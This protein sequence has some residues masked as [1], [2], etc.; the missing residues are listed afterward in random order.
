MRPYLLALLI[1]FTT[2]SCHRESSMTTGWDYNDP[3]NGGFQKVPFVEQETGPGLVLIEGGTFELYLEQDSIISDKKMEVVVP[4]YYLDEKEVSNYAYLEY[5]YWTKRTFSIDFPMVYTNALP[6]TLV[7]E[8]EMGRANNFVDN[9][10]RHPA[11]NNYPVVGVSWMQANNYCDWRTDRVNEFILI[12]EGILTYNP[13][14]INED[15]F[16]TEAYYAGQYESCVVT[17]LPDLD[18]MRAGGMGRKDLGERIVRME[19]GILLPHY[20]LP[21][22]AEWEYAASGGTTIDKKMK[23]KVDASLLHLGQFIN[24]SYYDDETFNTLMVSPVDAYLPNDLG[25]YNLSGNVSE[26]VSDTY[27]ERIDTSLNMHSPFVGPKTQ[28]PKESVHYKYAEKLSLVAYDIEQFEYFMDE[29]KEGYIP[30]NSKDSFAIVVFSRLDEYIDL[31]KQSEA[32]GNYMDA[33]EIMMIISHDLFDEM[34]YWHYNESPFGHEHEPPLLIDIK[35]YLAKSI[36]D[37]PG[38]IQF[39]GVSPYDRI[40][41][42]NNDSKDYPVYDSIIAQNDQRVYKGANW[43][44]TEKWV[45]PSFRRHLS[46]FDGSAVVGFRCAMDR[47][48]S[49]V[50]LGKK[51]K[52]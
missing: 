22:E 1:L 3:K 49:P 42:R 8:N 51:K 7:W 25:I 50:G 18:P 52:K 5:L 30:E 34:K 6:D 44:D 17:N 10:L 40:K 32:K 48:G 2:L 19:D 24:P 47:V 36:V 33:S 12:R 27:V 16:N 23:K 9:Y 29:L 20:R 28:V 15:H 13:N 31:A 39:E 11:Y 14:Q 46:K 43:S 26:W 45:E 38:S 35:K 21:T 4:S 41:Y 37:L